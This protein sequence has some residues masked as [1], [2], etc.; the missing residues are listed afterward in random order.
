MYIEYKYTHAA[1]HTQTRSVRGI[2]HFHR[3]VKHNI[4]KYNI[5]TRRRTVC[6][7]FSYIIYLHTQ[8]LK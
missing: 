1:V 6:K 5:L 3:R 8:A 7:P 2:L 4:I